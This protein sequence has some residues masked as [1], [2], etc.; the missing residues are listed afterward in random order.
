MSELFTLVNILG[1]IYFCF[2]ISAG[3][4]KSRLASLLLQLVAFIFIAW[5]SLILGLTGFFILIVFNILR[6]FIFIASEKY[7]WARNKAWA[8]SFVS[9]SAVWYLAITPIT[10]AW[11]LIPL[12]ARTIGVIGYSSMDNYKS[13]QFS[14]VAILLWLVYYAFAGLWSGFFTDCVKL[15]TIALS[16][17]RTKRYRD[18]LAAKAEDGIV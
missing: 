8:V 11:V 18:E 7:D 10:A 4:A 5:Q 2:S 17:P 15:L 12:I 3:W 1:A 16:L 9:I 6:H 14:I 13:K